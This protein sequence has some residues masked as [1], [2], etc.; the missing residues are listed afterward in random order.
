MQHRYT[1]DRNK[2]SGLVQVL[3][4]KED[5]SKDFLVVIKI[6]RGPIFTSYG[7]QPTRDLIY[8]SITRQTPL[9]TVNRAREESSFIVIMPR[10]ATVR[11]FEPKTHSKV[12]ID[13]CIGSSMCKILE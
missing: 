8:A 1:E 5:S 10:E 4:Y 11:W 3:C 2:N 12:A 6:C 13:S 7:S 9:Q